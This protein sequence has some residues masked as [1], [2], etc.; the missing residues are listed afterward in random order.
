MAFAKEAK[1]GQ[2]D[3]FGQVLAQADWENALVAAL[4]ILLVLVIAWIAMSTIKVRLQLKTRL[5][6]QG[7][8]AGETH[9]ESAKWVETLVRLLRQGV[10]FMLWVV[11]ILIV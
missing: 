4:S 11:V 8:V 7:K 2:L 6:H 5:I 3:L 9:S 10:T 1:D